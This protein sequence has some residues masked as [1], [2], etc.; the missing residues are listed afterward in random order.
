MTLQ[1]K[2]CREI[3]TKELLLVFK[4]A[5]KMSK[6]VLWMDIHFIF[7]FILLFYLYILS[8]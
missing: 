1:I 8:S 5:N 2:S 4:G 3:N 7:D 6:R